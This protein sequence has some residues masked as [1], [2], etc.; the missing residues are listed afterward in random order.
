MRIPIFLVATLCAFAA[1][2][3]PP[4]IGE[5]MASEIIGQRNACLNHEAQ[6]SAELADA[7]QQIEDLKAKIPDAK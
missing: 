3:D 7:R 5:R 6:L 1:L 2:A 4:S